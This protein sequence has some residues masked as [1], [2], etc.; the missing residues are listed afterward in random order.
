MAKILRKV[1]KRLN[2]RKSHWQSNK[3]KGQHQHKAPG[4]MK[5]NRH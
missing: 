3:T 1:E 2:S 5:I 4:S